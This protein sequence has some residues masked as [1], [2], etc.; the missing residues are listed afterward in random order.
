MDGIKIDVIGNVAR[1]IERPARITAGTVGLPVEFSFDSQWDG[2]IKT[3][4]FRAGNVCKSR[5]NLVMKTIVPWEVLE[6]P[7]LALEIG[8]YGVNADGTVAIATIWAN[9]GIIRDA[10][11][12]IKDSSIDPT[13]PVWKQLSNAIG[14][15]P[16]L[17][18]N[19]K[20]NIVEAINELH[21]IV[22]AGGNET[23][24]VAD[25][26]VTTLVDIDSTLTQE[27][28]AADAKATG[29]AIKAITPESIGALAIR[30]GLMEDFIYYRN[31]TAGLFWKTE[32]GTIFKIR[33]YSPSNLLQITA[34]APG[35]AETGIFNIPNTFLPYFSKPLSMNGNKITNLAD[36]AEDT[37]AV[38]LGYVKNL[39]PT[40]SD[41]WNV[42]E[43]AANGTLGDAL[44]I[45]TDAA[46]GN[47]NVPKLVSKENTDNIPTNCKFGI[48]TVEWYSAN[49]ILCRILGVNTSGMPTIWV[50]YHDTTKGTWTG[51]MQPDMVQ[52]SDGCYYRL[53]DDGSAWPA[54]E[55]ITP[56]M[57]PNVEYRT[58]ER[59][60]GKP[61][62]CK[63][64]E[65]GS[66]DIPSSSGSK[67]VEIG[68]DHTKVVR[69]HCFASYSTNIIGLPYADNTGTSLT[70]RVLGTG[71]F[72]TASNAS[73]SGYTA[74]FTVYY[75][76]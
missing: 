2:L 41:K 66:A 45:S 44:S 62:Y 25:E 74:N 19:A 11:S 14:D 55:W 3:A 51:W 37:D 38:N 7:G 63:V 32:D 52:E 4:V 60:K 23:A 15:L 31:K 21:S 53:V 48:R 49:N 71:L 30:G 17:A 68:I 29:D 40:G 6:S 24:T 70:V 20:D 27:G 73:F 58:A 72:F 8:A 75:V 56:P 22:S 59:W 16:E 64:F 9:I 39:I 54:I 34:Q 69:Y 28:K 18:T 12:P 5:E 67:R 65:I 43:A 50:N 46:D 10:V 76:K 26:T 36:P 61:V 35:G 47:H 33:P 57:H 42:K 1:V 13:L